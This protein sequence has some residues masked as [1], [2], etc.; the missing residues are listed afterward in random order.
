MRCR[1]LLPLLTVLSAVG[2]GGCG[3]DSKIQGMSDYDLSERYSHCLDH[4]PTAPGQ[5]QICENLRRECESR[6]KELGRFVCRTR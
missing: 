6:R 1:C 4:E 3:G 2:L 5:G